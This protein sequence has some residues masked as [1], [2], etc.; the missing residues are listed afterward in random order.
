MS[1][2]TNALNRYDVIVQTSYVYEKSLDE[3]FL[4]I[5]LKSRFADERSKDLGV[6]EEHEQYFKDS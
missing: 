1:L 2:H 6:V 4:F 5:T 3:I